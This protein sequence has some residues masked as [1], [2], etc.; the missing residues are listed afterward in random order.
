MRKYFTKYSYYLIILSTQLFGNNINKLYFNSEQQNFSTMIKAKSTPTK[1]Y[2]VV[3]TLMTLMCAYLLIVAVTALTKGK[4]GT[5]I[6]ALVVGAV[7]SAF[8]LHLYLGQI[9]SI[10]LLKNEVHINTRL[11]QI[12]IPYSVIIAVNYEKKISAPLL[13]VLGI[14]MIPGNLA[15]HIS[16]D[17]RKHKYYITDERRVFYIQTHTHTYHLSCDTYREIVDMIQKNVLSLTKG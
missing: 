5:S 3:T 15:K 7:L 2:R 14:R 9:Q 17:H 4:L 8:T 6:I 10:E 16:S 12:I 13:Q 11:S 1:V